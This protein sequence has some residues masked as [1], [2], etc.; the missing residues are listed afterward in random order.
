MEIF[1]FLQ[2]VREQGWSELR[3]GLYFC[4]I[5]NKISGFFP[6]Y[7]KDLGYKSIKC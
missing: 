4:E 1:H 3:R 7:G 5:F 6:T 2:C